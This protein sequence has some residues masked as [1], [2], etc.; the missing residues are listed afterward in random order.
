MASVNRYTNL[1]PAKY[2]PR[3][4]QELMMVPMYKRGQHDAL[5]E[6]IAATEAA[7]GQVD[8]LDIHSER[9]RFEQQ[10][11]YDQL[12]QQAEQLQQK[13]FG[14]TSTSDF[15]RLNKQYQQAI[16]PTGDLGRIQLAKP[17]LDKARSL[18]IEN[19]TKGGLS[20]DVAA[21][22]WED[23][24]A[25]YIKKFNET[26]KIEN[27]SDR[28]GAK[29]IDVPA[30]LIKLFTAAGVE[31]GDLSTLTSSIIKQDDGGSYVL[32]KGAANKY[33]SNKER[34]QAAVN[35]INN[36]IKNPESEIG[37]SLKEQRKSPEQ[38][39]QEVEGLNK[40]FEKNITD[41]S[42]SSQIS[43]YSPATTL[44]I[45][46]DE[47]L[48]HESTEA[49]SVN[50]NFKSIVDK[51]SRIKNKVPIN[52][53]TDPT[54]IA[55]L[56]PSGFIPNKKVGEVSDFNN[57][58]SKKEMEEYTNMANRIIASNPALKGKLVTSPEVLD[59]VS[60]YSAQNSN[61]LR[62]NA[63]I[64][65]DFMTTYGDNSI[66]VNKTD[67]EKIV[68]G[69]VANKD[70][71]KYF[72]NGEVVSYDKLP[73]DIKKDFDKLTFSGYYSPKN[74]LTDSYGGDANKNL[75]VTP[76][77]LKHTNKDGQV[78]EVLVSRS[79][80]EMNRASFKADSAFNDV[81]VNT[82]KYAGLAYDIPNAN[83]EVTYYP[84]GIPYPGAPAG[85]KYMMSKK[86]NGNYE[87]N[88][89]F[90]TESNLQNMF[91]NWYGVSTSAKTKNK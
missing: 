6:K 80:G 7:L 88:P 27:I 78:T 33:S 69:I 28:F 91:Y 82:N 55:G 48:E 29:Y 86:V 39:L 37:R 41:T 73:S 43:G 22:N 84:D 50:T 74:F 5:T 85:T 25:E 17:A 16:S 49:E 10:K 34:L 2:T 31:G 44:G 40:I 42:T 89:I 13:G 24:K 15:Q 60:Q 64:T 63:L 21:A 4:L 23:H 68:K 18:Y 79:S 14:R 9:A 56:A 53:K 1:E 19:A 11:L 90:L 57:Q 45:P 30:E 3:T 76:I 38:A 72:I 65:S 87:G 12:T 46:S 36:Q 32:T 83:A 61:I 81:F 77:S 67:P 59:A 26:G 51:L 35:Y 8:P 71:R 66:G 75:F 20:S 62:Q 47:N 52:P 70:L 58:F 54:Y